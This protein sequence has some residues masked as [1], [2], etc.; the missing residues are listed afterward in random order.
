MADTKLTA[1]ER[2]ALLEAEL[3]KAQSGE[4]GGID[5][6][7]WALAEKY[8]KYELDSVKI[9]CKTLDV[10]PTKEQKKE[11]FD[12]IVEFKYNILINKEDDDWA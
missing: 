9:A 12:A 11:I 6:E 1:E 8:T 3:E 5:P 10:N 7:K 2:I 4:T